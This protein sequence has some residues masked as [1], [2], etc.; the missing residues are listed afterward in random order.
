[1]KREESC[2]WKADLVKER[3]T[4]KTEWK[5]FGRALASKPQWTVGTPAVPTKLI[6]NWILPSREKERCH[7]KKV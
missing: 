1:M 2:R 4:R 7:S 6:L 5:T 3:K